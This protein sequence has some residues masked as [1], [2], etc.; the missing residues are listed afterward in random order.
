[1]SGRSPPRAR[2]RPG[3]RAPMPALLTRMSSRPK[4]ATASSTARVDLI[5]VGDVHLQRQR[6]P[7]HRLDLRDQ[8]AAGARTSRRPS[9]TSAPAWASASEIARPRP[10]AA[11][12]TSA[13]WPSRLKLGK[14]L[15]ARSI[16]EGREVASRRAAR[17]GRP[18]PARRIEPKVGSARERRL[19]RASR[20]VSGYRPLDRLRQPFAS[21]PSLPISDRAREHRR[22]SGDD[23]FGSGSSGTTSTSSS[24]HR[25]LFLPPLLMILFRQKIPRWWFDWN[26]ELLRFTD[27]VGISWR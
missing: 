24:A 26:V 8:V 14:S 25:V 18:R 16:P 3:S 15:I 9:A 22:Y 7:P 23:G 6:A 27:R 21:S 12:V 2:P 5:E 4:P 19:S 10:R 1:M 20:S 13:T 17:Y 11:P